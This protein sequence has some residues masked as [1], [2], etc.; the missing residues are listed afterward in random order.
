MSYDVLTDALIDIDMAEIQQSQIITN[1][2]NP[3]SCW[4]KN[5]DGI[6]H[7]ISCILIVFL[8]GV[9]LYLFLY[10]LKNNI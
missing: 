9:F 3:N 10:M 4:E 1:T 8:T 7:G 6:K 5:K 2:S